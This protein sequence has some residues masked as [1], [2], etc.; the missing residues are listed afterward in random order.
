MGDHYS[1]AMDVVVL[2][3]E[4]GAETFV[5]LARAWASLR[6]DPR[7]RGRLRRR[8]KLPGGEACSGRGTRHSYR[9]EKGTSPRENPSVRPKREEP[10]IWS[11]RRVFCPD[12]CEFELVVG[13]HPFDDWTD[14]IDMD[15]WI[16]LH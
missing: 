6:L 12:L 13:L 11:R 7:G 15:C 5:E 16:V 9:S 2:F 4:I 3:V 10:P 1:T 8:T 14:Y